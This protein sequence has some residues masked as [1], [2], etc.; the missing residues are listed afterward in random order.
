MPFTE[1]GFGAAVSDPEPLLE[2]DSSLL[3]S[4]SELGWARSAGWWLDDE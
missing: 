1:R 3:S 4:S 2:Q